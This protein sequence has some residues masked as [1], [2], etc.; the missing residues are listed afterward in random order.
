MRDNTSRVLPLEKLQN[1]RDLGGIQTADGRVILPDSLIR[2]GHLCAASAADQAYISGAVGL[3]IDFRTEKERGEK[4]DP[5][6]SGTRYLHLPVFQDLAAGITRDETSDRRAFEIVAKDP[7]AARK[8]M[9]D[10][11][12]GFV[13]DAFCT[14]QYSRFLRC[15]LDVRE[16]AVLWHCTAGKDRAGFAAA[17]V[18]HLLGVARGDIIADYMKT[19]ECNRE[20]VRKLFG[21]VGRRFGGLTEETEEALSF[22]FEAKEEY[23]TAALGEAEERYGSLDGF[24]E[25]GLNFSAE[26]RTALRE[27]YLK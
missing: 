2:S 22:L 16:R 13:T 17:L 18:L 6:I 10:T 27:R 1:T 12:L 15:L 7:L 24:I 20:E 14:E 26:D 25:K 21:M 8:Y 9:I 19:N 4:P 23:L 3:I 5:D 11:Y